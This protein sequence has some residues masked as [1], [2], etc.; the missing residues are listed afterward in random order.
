MSY[1]LSV[2]AFFLI[3]VFSPMSDLWLLLFDC[4]GTLV[5][6]ETLIVEAMVMAF[7]R[8]HMAPPDRSAIRR[9]IGL[10]LPLAIEAL[11]VPANKGLV[12]EIGANYKAAYA[13]LRD[14]RGLVEPLFAGV[15]GLISTLRGEEH[16]LL[17]IA[18]GK[19]RKG[20]NSLLS[21]LG[22]LDHFQTIQTSCSAPSK[23]HPAMIEQA[24]RETGVRADRT[25]MIGDTTFDMEMAQN[26]GT[27]AIG[28]TW[29]HHFREDLAAFNPQH[30]VGDM[31]ELKEV[32]YGFIS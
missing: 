14:E 12:N 10:S 18:T 23:P 2:F 4:D 22:W 24:M 8:A 21:G 17:G 28:V 27:L 15:S 29:G 11:G 26:A 16:V 20:V 13:E 7:Q 6:S 9:I 30:I 5:D 32:L 31:A 3:K 19:T 1:R 25:L